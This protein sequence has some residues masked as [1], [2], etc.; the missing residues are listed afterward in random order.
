MKSLR[1][2]AATAWPGVLALVLATV[3]VYSLRESIGHASERIMHAWLPLLLLVPYRALPLA[4][5]ALGWWI[6]LARTVPY[7]FYGGP[8]PY[9][10]A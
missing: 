4:L 3:I 10:M 5:D 2:A 1:N 9:A 8:R 7:R 6:L